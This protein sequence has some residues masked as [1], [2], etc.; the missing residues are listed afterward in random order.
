MLCPAGSDVLENTDRKR[1]CTLA[2]ALTDNVRKHAMADAQLPTP[3]ELRQL[4]RYE[5][6]TGKLF[7]RR[8]GPEYFASS[9]QASS[10]QLAAL[11]NKKFAGKEAMTAIKSTGYH[12]GSVRGK[13]VL[14]HRAAFAIYHGMWP[15]QIDHINGE[16]RD[17]RIENLRSVTAS[18]N[19]KN[20]AKTRGK[21][22]RIGVYFVEKLGKW[23]AQVCSQGK[24]RTLGV[25]ETE[26]EAIDA[27]Q[28]AEVR[29]GFH[30]NHGRKL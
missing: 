12:H 7:W 24:K 6:E 10:E 18:E 2:P 26:E 15:D 27:R 4:L 21:N 8:R 9:K 23:S 25:F 14:A 3:T 29:F 1:G 16:R 30:E 19:H 13:M 11:W 20:R 5:P 28:R 17:N 22:D